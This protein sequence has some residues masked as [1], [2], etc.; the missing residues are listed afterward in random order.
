MAKIEIKQVVTGGDQASADLGRTADAVRKLGTEAGPTGAEVEKLTKKKHDLIN[1]A[2]GATREIPILGEVIHALR[3]PIFLVGTAVGIAVE[4][5]RSLRE[6]LKE[7][8][9]RW[10]G[11]ASNVSISVNAFSDAKKAIDALKDSQDA[12]AKATDHANKALEDQIAKLGESIDQQVKLLEA[13]KE[14]EAARIERDVADPVERARRLRQ[15]EL[16]F[17]ARTAGLRGSLPGQQAAIIGGQIAAERRLQ[18]EA[19]EGVPNE[20]QLREQVRAVE[21]T[22]FELQG[23]HAETRAASQQAELIQMAIREGGGL[24]LLNAGESPFGSAQLAALRAGGFT[25]KGSGIG[26]I[27]TETLDIAKLQAAAPGAQAKLALAQQRT[28]RLQGSLNLG[29]G[30]LPAG[31][32][33]EADVP[34][35]ISAAE[36]SAAG[37]QNASYAREQAL[38]ARQVGLLTQQ[39]NTVALNTLSQQLAGIKGDTAIAAAV[40][41]EGERLAKVF[42]DVLHKIGADTKRAS[43]SAPNP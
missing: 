27:A 20:A 4:A 5:F 23:S 25:I 9:E 7:Q 22:R 32:A 39:Q 36:T 12:L 10:E 19:G 2:R 11:Y 38:R 3:H 16:I 41:Q 17:G 26:G 21:K 15:N 42:I 24:N 31:V 29:I 30:A 28:A 13:Q 1:A 37:V 33:T 40:Q 35:F 43:Q 6:E 8:R 34:G 14:V 18:V